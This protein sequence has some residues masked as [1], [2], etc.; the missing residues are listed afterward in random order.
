MLIG[1]K[2]ILNRQPINTAH[3]FATILFE[4]ISQREI[5]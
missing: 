3:G 1:G 2:S 4:G 5:T